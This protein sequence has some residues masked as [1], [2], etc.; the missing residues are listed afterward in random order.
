MKGMNCYIA[1][2]ILISECVSI[3]INDI[4]HDTSML[5]Q[6]IPIE[7]CCFSASIDTCIDSQ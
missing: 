6:H 3:N 5:A 7:Y 4:H 1:K 2:Q